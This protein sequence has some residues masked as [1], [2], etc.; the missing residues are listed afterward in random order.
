MSQM[1]KYVKCD[2]SQKSP[3]HRRGLLLCPVCFLL[4]LLVDAFA[5]DVLGGFHDGFGQGRVGVDGVH[6]LSS[7]VDS[8]LM[9][10]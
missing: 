6:Q 9:E 2:R 10:T 4:G 1:Y 3:R 5:F 8:N 7:M